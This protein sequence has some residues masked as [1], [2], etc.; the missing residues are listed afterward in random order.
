MEKKLQDQA[1]TNKV[2]AADTAQ[3]S[4]DSKMTEASLKREDLSTKDS[5]HQS[6][7]QRTEEEEGVTA[8]SN[9]EGA[10]TGNGEVDLAKLFC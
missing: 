1:Q 4:G 6:S 3:S 2:A 8:T 7:V 9:L 10:E 5:A